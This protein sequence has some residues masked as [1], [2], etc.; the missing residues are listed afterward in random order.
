MTATSRRENNRKN[1]ENRILDAALNVFSETGYSG[2][3]MDAIAVA[4]GVSKP[5]LYQYFGAKDQLFKAMMKQERVQLLTMFQNVSG[6]RMVDDLHKFAWFYADIVMR[7][8]FL[9]LA[10]LIIGEAQRFPDIGRFYQASGPNH[11]LH[12]M[13]TYL[14]T[15][16][17]NGR[18]VFDDPELAAEDLWG[19]LLS[20][21][22]NQA[23]HVPDEI[24]GKDVLARYI[25]NG[26]RV[27]LKA[28]STDPKTDLSTL[29]SLLKT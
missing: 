4:A 13:M 28:Y 12:A 25:N 10:R 3:S 7:P 8:D 18:L 17:A 21:P 11:I 29:D 22:R 15:Q 20:A 5:T 23:L 6:D 14:D 9:S 24:L 19:L 16:R 27:F 2:A 26:L 1:K